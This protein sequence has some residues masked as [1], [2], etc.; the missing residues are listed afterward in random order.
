MLTNTVA[1]KTWVDN[2]GTGTLSDMV[3]GNRALIVLSQTQEVHEEIE[4]TL[5]MLRKAG[6]LK[7]AAENV[8]GEDRDGELSVDRPAPR[9]RR[10][11]PP[12][13]GMG[14]MGGGMMGGM[15]GGMGAM[16]GRAGDQTPFVISVIPV[17]GPQTAPGGD[18]DLLG[19]LKSS[20]AAN[21]K[22]EGHA[23]QATPG[24][25]SRPK[26]HDGRDGRRHG[27]KFLITSRVGQASRTSGFPA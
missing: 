22:G 11:A 8:A 5:E 2:G 7:A 16:N 14:G 24:R 9:I 1:T 10:P 18:A 17:V 21:Q 26:W 4:D 27:R 19:G 15:G 12:A 23:P 13:G 20:N 25:R 6:G 3:V